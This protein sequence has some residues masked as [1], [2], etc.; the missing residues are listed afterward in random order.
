MNAL[1]YACD[2]RSGTG[3]LVDTGDEISVLPANT[4][5]RCKPTTR[6]LTAANCTQIKTWG[7]KTISFHLGHRH[8]TW[9]F[10]VAAVEGAILGSDCLRSSGLRID[11]KNN[12]LLDADNLAAMPLKQTNK[13]PLSLESFSLATDLYGH[14]LA[15]FPSIT[16]LTFAAATIKHVIRTNG[17]LPHA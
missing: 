14:L 7:R 8:F 15:K 11:V 1:F 9:T 13:V 4:A 17:P 16:T 12:R 3:F 10:T 6:P 2:P 5:T